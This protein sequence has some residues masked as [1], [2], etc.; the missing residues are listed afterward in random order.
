MTRTDG[1]QTK[2]RLLVQA[3]VAYSDNPAASRA[4]VV[5]FNWMAQRVQLAPSHAGYLGP[6][7]PGTQSATLASC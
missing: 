4:S 5:K 3:A 6:E 1:F 7:R 2:R